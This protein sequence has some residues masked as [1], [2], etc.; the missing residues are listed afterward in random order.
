MKKNKITKLMLI[1]VMALLVFSLFACGPKNTDNGGG[2]NTSKKTLDAPVV[3]VNE[4]GLAE[5]RPIDGAGSYRVTVYNYDG[6]V[7]ATKE[8]AEKVYQYQLEEGE[9]IEVVALPLEKY[10]DRY[11]ESEKSTKKAYT[12]ST[13]KQLVN[14]LNGVGGIVDT[15]NSA[16]NQ[17][18]ADI[19]LG[20]FFESGA[21][22]QTTGKKKQNSFNVFAQANA[23]VNDPEFMLGFKLN[24]TD[25]LSLGYKDNAIYVREPMNLFNDLS[26]DNKAPQAYKIDV[27]ALADC[28]PEIMGPVMKLVAADETDLQIASLIDDVA[29]LLNG[30]LGSLANIFNVK[31]GANGE[32]IISATVSTLSL[33][34]NFIKTMPTLQPFI[35]DGGKID[36]YI[37]YFYKVTD[38]LKMDR[39][40]LNGED[41]S[42]SGI[43]ALFP[44]GE[45][46]PRYDDLKNND[47][48]NIEVSY[49]GAD[50]S[51]L[52]LVLDLGA[53][54][55]QGLDYR[56][57]LTIGLN[58]FSTTTPVTINTNGFVAK[59]F[60]INLGG[61]LGKKFISI[62]DKKEVL[63]ADAKA[64]IRLS[65]ALKDKGNK[66]AT[67]SIGKDLDK[68][69]DLVG[70]IDA[71]GVYV[72]FAPV[73]SI[74]EN[75]AYAGNTKY[76]AT[77]LSDGANVIDKLVKDFKDNKPIAKAIDE[78]IANMSGN[79]DENSDNTTP[80]EPAQPVEPEQPAEPAPDFSIMDIIMEIANEFGAAENKVDY[81]CS[82]I[83]PL[84]MTID[85]EAANFLPPEGT[86]ITQATVIKY[87][88]NRTLGNTGSKIADYAL[89]YKN[90]QGVEA[91]TFEGLWTNIKACHEAGKAA[92]I[93][94]TNTT[95]TTAGIQFF[96]ADTPENDLLD[97]IAH[98]VKIPTIDASNT[99][100]FTNLAEI[101]DKDK[102]IA[103]LNWIFPVDNEY[104]VMV[105]DILGTGLVNVIGKV[106]FEA[107]NLGGF[108]GAIRIA[109]S[110]EI[111][112]EDSYVYLSAGFG[113][114]ASAAA[115]SGT[116]TGGKA[117]NEINVDTGRYYIAEM[118]VDLL[119]ALRNYGKAA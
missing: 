52:N 101:N 75:S 62:G 117:F 105:E 108:N 1:L 5:W 72:D 91:T 24:E 22:D 95:E 85:A 67:L 113:M 53:L 49:N 57:G 110:K 114:N 77:Y 56:F 27:T 79:N 78:L 82:V 76:Q 26:G 84:I 90:D 61:I 83:Y 31:D 102:L 3:I 47:L 20:G 59:D 37:G 9:S 73:F 100:N 86:P 98:F 103:W 19:A 66:W 99:P 44:T 65:D 112:N 34:I 50:I 60:E 46:D 15:W 11:N 109:A 25:Y 48:L 2:G 107:I 18:Y 51:G 106:Y 87:V 94:A 55:I 17:L 14:L 42:M 69:L 23:N 13:A 92:L 111:P 8:T 32:K 28:I 63:S 54:G 4:S 40:Q 71:T 119:T 115:P 104:R 30:E 88:F 96:D 35:K 39:I 36:E 118:A 89:F 29:A 12:L 21:I 81:V 6:T 7:K 58:T 68:G 93:A 43:L 33:G 80:D 45:D 10:K 74:L 16:T 41:L 38:A 64:V 116:I 97:Y 70:Y